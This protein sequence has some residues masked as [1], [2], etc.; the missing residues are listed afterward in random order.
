MKHR[1]I[2]S[3]D[4]SPINNESKQGEVVVHIEGE[5]SDLV[6]LWEALTLNLAKQLNTPYVALAMMLLTT[7]QSEEKAFTKR[8]ISIDLSRLTKD[9]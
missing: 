8:G 9:E 7:T 5:Q 6:Y 1:A 3:A 2:L 4:M